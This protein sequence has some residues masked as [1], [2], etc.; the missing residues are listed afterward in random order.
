MIKTKTRLEIASQVYVNK[1]DIRALFLVSYEVACRIYN[2]AEQLESKNPYRIYPTKVRLTTVCKI[3]NTTIDFLHKQAV[4]G[5][6]LLQKE[7]R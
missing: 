3:T 2:I 4:S 1:N 6:T 5:D 7:V